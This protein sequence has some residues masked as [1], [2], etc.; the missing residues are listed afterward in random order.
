MNISCHISVVKTCSKGRTV[1][2]KKRLKAGTIVVV[3]GPIACVPFAFSTIP[4]LN[5]DNG[6]HK[7]S[8]EEKLLQRKLKSSSFHPGL[9]SGNLC[10]LASRFYYY[11]LLCSETKNNQERYHLIKNHVTV[12]P[13]DMIGL[14]ECAQIV[15][16][17]VDETMSARLPQSQCTIR[18]ED[19]IEII[20]KL[21]CNLFTIVDDFQNEAGIGCYPYASLINHS[22]AP[23][24]IQRFDENANIIIRCVADIELAEELTI[25]YI[26][27]GR[28]TWYRQQELL[29]SYHFHC[30]CARCTATDLSDGYICIDV[31]CEPNCAVGTARTQT[32]GTSLKDS[33]TGRTVG[34][35]RESR[36][37]GE[38][39]YRSWRLGAQAQAQAQPHITTAA[40]ALPGPSRALMSI[41]LPFPLSNLLPYVDFQC[42]ACSKLRPGRDILTI[43]EKVETAI[44]RF[45]T[46]P[47]D[48]T[49]ARHL[50]LLWRE[51]EHCLQLLEF[52]RQ[53]VSE[54]HYCML[55][56]RKQLKEA[57]EKY[58]PVREGTLL[59]PV[60][61]VR[62]SFK[63]TIERF[64]ENKYFISSHPEH[65]EKSVDAVVFS[66]EELRDLYEQNLQCILLSMPQCYSHAVTNL[67]YVYFR[68]QYVWFVLS[69]PHNLLPPR[70]DDKSR[71][72][73]QVRQLL[74][75]HPA[76]LRAVKTVYGE[77][78]AF[79]ID[80]VSR[81]HD[82][83][84]LLRR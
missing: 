13:S 69:K 26:D 44:M 66:A 32:Q 2:A 5:C 29:K 61:A 21:S 16:F 80:M 82:L 41:N 28:P 31:Q 43:I 45:E 63:D 75:D 37:S 38:Q 23:N 64:G 67:C 7:L 77:E 84:L 65:S 35:C 3:E 39:M 15:K 57:M 72:P 9:N 60:L 70:D 73:E 11:G 56:V 79:Y 58:L 71:G 20:H 53:L 52:I 68:I 22:C 49:A 1:V 47:H 24:C 54:R 30:Q 76:L 74:V 19:C 51:I 50:E 33:F 36:R 6:E 46:D 14:H 78:H 55:I 59:F 4:A 83:A 27:T 12:G 40:S 17:L 8:S 25:S 18:V 42:C 10:M 81:E 62:L 48:G 34:I